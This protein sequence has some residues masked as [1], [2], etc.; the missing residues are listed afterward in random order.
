MNAP[1]MSDILDRPITE[2]KRPTPLPTGTYLWIVRGLPRYDSAGTGTK[3]AEFTLE[4]QRALDDVDEGEL[5]ALLVN[6]GGQAKTLVNFTQKLKFYL[7]EEAGWR[8]KKFLSD[9]GFD[10]EEEGITPRQV[11]EATSGCEVYGKIAHVP[12]KDG[13]GIYAQISE[14]AQVG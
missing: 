1:K 7:T 5:S 3:F 2:I 10:V 12:T 9:C 14:T 13:K 11:C 4:P 6:E 8:I